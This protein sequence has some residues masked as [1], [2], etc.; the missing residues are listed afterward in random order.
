MVSDV[1][2]CTFLP[3]SPAFVYYRVVLTV[4]VF[5]EVLRWDFEQLTPCAVCELVVMVIESNASF[6]ILAVKSALS[7]TGKSYDLRVGDGK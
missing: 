4:I 5:N 7:L 2:L 6:E 3:I 1:V